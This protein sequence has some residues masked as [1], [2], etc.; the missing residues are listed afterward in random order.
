MA[1]LTRIAAAWNRAIIVTQANY[2]W[3]LDLDSP[4][5][6]L[7]HANCIHDQL[8]AFF[9]EDA[10]SFFDSSVPLVT[11]V[12]TQPGPIGELPEKTVEGEK[13]AP[14]QRK[15]S[16]RQFDLVAYAYLK[17]ELVNTPNSQAV[18]YLKAKCPKLVAFVAFMDVLFSDEENLSTP[19]LQLESAVT[20]DRN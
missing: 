16:L 20:A 1:P 15:L 12:N 6:I 7:N 17:E 10:C 18:A 4:A 5:S 9:K 19:G 14:P 13:E 11:S 8:E 2:A 3:G